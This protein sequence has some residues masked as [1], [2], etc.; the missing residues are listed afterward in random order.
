MNR[1][2]KTSGGG[3]HLVSCK[4]S[5]KLGVTDAF[6]IHA[7]EKQD[8]FVLD[9]EAILKALRDAEIFPLDR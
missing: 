9:E 7:A 6:P 8:N 5:T 3:V 4:G 2:A 1:N